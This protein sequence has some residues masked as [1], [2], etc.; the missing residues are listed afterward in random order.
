MIY[1]KK[2]SENIDDPFITANTLVALNYDRE[3]V[4]NELLKLEIFDYVETLIDMKDEN[5]P[6]LYVFIKKIQKRDV[7]IKIKIRK[8]IN[9]QV[10]CISF[11]FARYKNAKYP[12]KG[13]K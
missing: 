13:V 7:Y 3:D 9:R 5:G 4:K 11:H 12:Y 2:K 1:Y 10:F 8:I 6:R